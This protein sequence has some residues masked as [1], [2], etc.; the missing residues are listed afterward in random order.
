VTL[1]TGVAIEPGATDFDA[2]DFIQAA[3]AELPGAPQA[4]KF[5]VDGLKR[6]GGDDNEPVF[7]FEA[8]VPDPA[9]TEIF[10]EGPADWYPDVPKPVQGTPAS[11]STWRFTFDRLGAK[12]PIAKAPIRFTVI[13]GGHAIEKTVTLD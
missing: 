3:A 2:A 8:H 5:D 10:V 11:P 9:H 4:G 1:D 13:S 12:T 6:A 7:E